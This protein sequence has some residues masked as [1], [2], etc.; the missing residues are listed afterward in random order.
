MAAKGVYLKENERNVFYPAALYGFVPRFD[1]EKHGQLLEG[2]EK[3][4]L[5]TRDPFTRARSGGQ[6]ELRSVHFA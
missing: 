6:T 5:N 4:F 2:K 1:T 3:R